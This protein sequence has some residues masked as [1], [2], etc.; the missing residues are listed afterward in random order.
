[1]PTITLREITKSDVWP[2]SQLSRTLQKPQSKALA[3]NAFS[4]AEA[5]VNPS[6][7]AQAIYADDDPVGFLMLDDKPDKQECLLWRLMIAAPHQGRGYGRDAIE[8]LID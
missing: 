2:V 1:M 4:L 8:R 3:P 7:W 6:A 5:H